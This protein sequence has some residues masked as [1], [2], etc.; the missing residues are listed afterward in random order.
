MS[1]FFGL[2]PDVCGHKC[3]FEEEA[4]LVGC[5]GEPGDL[6]LG[7]LGLPRVAPLECAGRRSAVLPV[8]VGRRT[9]AWAGF[10]DLF[11]PGTD[12]CLGRMKGD[13]L[14][15]WQEDWQSC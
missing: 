2:R 15:R 5:W 9:V 6:G 13:G 10:W 3:A 12:V 7:P 8:A 4:R 14:R 1:A 11:C